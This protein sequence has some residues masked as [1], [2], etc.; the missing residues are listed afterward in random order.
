M[1]K[2]DKTQNDEIID[3]QDD[4]QDIVDADWQAARDAC[5]DVLRHN[6]KDGESLRQQVVARSYT[7]RSAQKYLNLQ[8]D[9][10][11]RAVD[12][13]RLPSFADPEDRVRIPAY[14]IAEAENDVTYYEQV[15]FH[16]RLRSRDVA[17]V[18]GFSQA[19]MR[20]E[21]EQAQV[22]R[23]APRWG[24]IRGR[25]DLPETLA[26]FREA[27]QDRRDERAQA[28]KQAR[29]EAKNKR[30]EAVERERERRRELR[31][32]LRQSFDAWQQEDR[33][34][35][36]ILL[37]VGPPNSGKT[38]DALNRLAETG[39]G[40][41][42]APLRLLAFEIFDRLNQRGVRC[43]LLTG[44][45]YIRV[46]GATITAATIEM[47]NAQSSGECVIIDEAQMIADPDRGW[48]WT[49]A[50]IE[51]QAP[52]MHIIAPPTA[53]ELLV[54]M[55]NAADI[56]IGI[57]RHERL[58]PIKVADENWPLHELE[59]RTI[60]VA[61]SR[62]S[63]LELKAKLEQ[64]KRTVSV[65]YGSLP[66]EVRRRQADRFANGETEICV[67]TDAVGMGLNLPADYVCFYDV[68]KFDGRQIR[69][70]TP[71]EVHQIGG[72]AGR[73][74]ISQAG[75]VGA[76]TK[77]NLKI[78]RKLFHDQPQRLTHARVAPTVDDLDLIPGN[79]AEKLQEWAQLQTIPTKLRSYVSEA[80]LTERISL[81]N[82]L[83][84]EEVEMLGLEAA[85]KLIN[86]PT[87]KSSRDFWLQCV[88]AIIGEHAMPLPPHPPLSI[89]SSPDLEETE[90][91]ISCADIY[92]W[93]GHRQEFKLFAPDMEYVREERLQWSSSIDEALLKRLNIDLDY[94]D[95]RYDTNWS[96]RRR[97]DEN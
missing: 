37:H 13:G 64:A 45:E 73:Y 15:A 82:M 30:R 44:E 58:A 67:A 8:K 35:Q 69:Q 68:E 54:N 71:A 5:G 24:D 46:D 36:H 77:R 90:M 39:S 60:L 34:H 53:Q 14:A 97:R 94:R 19:K 47:F 91:C 16:E 12:E 85:V 26:E 61:F 48:A 55:A 96:P 52:E 1:S 21:L 7:I 74:G 95:Y 76:T 43:N 22:S 65:V 70:L 88:Y 10:V 83:S 66:P 62:R 6:A 57:V 17:F 25:W 49:R 38:H 89:D 59:P 11:Q 9:A 27:L 80:D 92:M 75:E 42:L 81:A 86:A 33:S 40:W 56:P 50:M 18:T 4:E 87:R 20:K 93:L 3:V 51:S 79:L 72:R 31:R 28:R 78:V 84:D 63:V 32:Q 41:Y 2:D 29:E 23:N